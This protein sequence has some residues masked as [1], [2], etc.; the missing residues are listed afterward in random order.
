MNRYV[1]HN[2]FTYIDHETSTV[3]LVNIHCLI[4]RYKIKEKEKNLFPCDEN[5]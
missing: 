1:Q 3:S 4:Y 2:D 5:S